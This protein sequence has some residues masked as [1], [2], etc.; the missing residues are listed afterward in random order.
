MDARTSLAGRRGRAAAEGGRGRELRLPPEGNDSFPAA[1]RQVIPGPA[2]RLHEAA[3]R[4]MAEAIGR[5]GVAVSDLER[6]AVVI[7]LRDDT[8]GQLLHE[9]NG[10]AHA[11]SE[12]GIQAQTEAVL[13]VRL[14]LRGYCVAGLCDIAMH[15]RQRPGRRRAADPPCSRNSADSTNRRPVQMSRRKRS[16]AARDGH[17][18]RAPGSSPPERTH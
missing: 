10:P 5:N 15:M 18:A 11:Q 17:P 9:G 6:P 16:T 4:R 1:R 14:D 7:P 3:D 12:Q 2:I 8:E 13:A